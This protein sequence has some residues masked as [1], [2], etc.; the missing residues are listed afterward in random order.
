MTSVAFS[1][2]YSPEHQK[3]GTELDEHEI[4]LAL[5]RFP[6]DVEHRLPTAS[7]VSVASSTKNS[8]VAVIHS[9]AS[10]QEIEEAVA[11]SAGSLRLYG[12]RLES[13]PPITHTR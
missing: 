8:V 1:I 4:T 2:Y 9:P 6:N 13:I 11:E 7:S 10:I 12:K 5:H 3:P